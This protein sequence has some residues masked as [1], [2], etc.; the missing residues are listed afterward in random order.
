MLAATFSL[1]L[2][3]K[4][5][6]EMIHN[7][8]LLVKLNPPLLQLSVHVWSRSSLPSQKPLC[9]PSFPRASEWYPPQTAYRLP[10]FAGM[11]SAWN[12][13][14]SPSLAS[15]PLLSYLHA[16]AHPRF[17]LFCAYFLVLIFICIFY[18]SSIVFSFMFSF[19]FLSL[20]ILFFHIFIVLYNLLEL[21]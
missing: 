17:H 7:F 3:L 5:I 8:P 1:S 12:R 18:Q 19:F 20:F 4:Y 16:N 21:Y 14:N 10:A 2:H 13:R 11:K 6:V 15:A 9:R